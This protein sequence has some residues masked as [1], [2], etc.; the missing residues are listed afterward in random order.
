MRVLHLWW[1]GR[2]RP[3]GAQTAVLRLLGPSCSGPLLPQYRIFAPNTGCLAWQVSM[4]IKSQL[5]CRRPV[6]L[7][8]C[9]SHHHSPHPLGGEDLCSRLHTQAG[10]HR[11]R[12]GLRQSYLLREHVPACTRTWVPTDATHT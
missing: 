11:P 12:V 8:S 5:A 3:S 2:Q 4:A 10:T 7:C 1:R 9:V 6:T